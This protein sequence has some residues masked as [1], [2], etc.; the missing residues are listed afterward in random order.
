MMPKVPDP[1]KP[2]DPV[3]VPSQTDPDVIANARAKADQEFRSR[4]GRDSTDLSGGGSPVYSRT[5]LG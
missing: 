3:R 1:P 5:T 2:P 4:R